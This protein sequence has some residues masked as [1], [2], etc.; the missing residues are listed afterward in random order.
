VDHTALEYYD[1]FAADPGFIILGDSP[2]SDDDL[3]A[4]A[5]TRQ[6]AEDH[7][8]WETG[9]DPQDL[10]AI[11]QKYFGLN[12][13]NF[14]NGATT[15]LDSGNVT[16]TGWDYN[17]GVYMVL[18]RQT[19]D[20]DGVITAT[21][22]RYYVGEDV[23]LD[24]LLPQETLA[25]MREYLLTGHD[26]GFADYQLVEVTF[27][28]KSDTDGQS[29]YLFYHSIQ[30][31]ERDEEALAACLAALQ[32]GESFVLGQRLDDPYDQAGQSTTLQGYLDDW[33]DI[34]D[35]RVTFTCDSFALCDLDRDGT[36]EVIASMTTGGNTNPEYMILHGENGTVYGYPVTYRALMDLKTDG[37][38]W[39]SCGAGDN[40]TDIMWFDGVNYVREDVTYQ[41]GGLT[42]DP[43]YYVD[44]E[45]TT[46]DCFNA[47]VISQDT[48]PDVVWY[49]LTAENLQTAFGL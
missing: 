26:E 22:R 29:S 1:L 19:A 3:S 25:H 41:V 18:D 20:D 28:E 48:K 47:A 46:E 17:G 45:E 43:H 23:W 40:G 42:D 7:Y 16:A 34:N 5:I 27:E 44:R 12:I 39:V 30:T 32:D 4:Y 33:T 36:P 35:G 11:T 15:V 14:E 37:S 49:D 6:A 8:E 13:G 31:L 21:F 38:F 9:C 2:F 24:D 10:T